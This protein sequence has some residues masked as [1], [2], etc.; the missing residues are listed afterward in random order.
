MKKLVLAAALATIAAPAMAQAP[1]KVSLPDA[2]PALW[3]VKDAD[4]IIYLF[5]TFHMLDGKQDWFND[6]VKTAFDKSDEVVLEALV[7]E[8]QASMVPL[9]QKYAVDP[10]GKTLTSKLSAEMKPRYV[11]ELAA[12]GLPAAAFDKFE[13][14]FATMALGQL[15]TAK[16][17]LKPEHGP[18]AIFTSAAKAKGLPMSQL[19]GVEYQLNLFDTMPE[20]QQIAFLGETL[21]SMGEMEKTLVPMVKAWSSGDTA[22][23][24]K[25]LN[26]GIDDDPALYD[27]L[28]TKRN[29]NWAE[30]I[31]NRLDRPGTVFVAVGAGHLAGKY[32]VQDLLGQRGI[33]SARV[34]K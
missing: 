17:G 5:G 32:S 11:K 27:L 31:D 18:E 22:S 8:N 2:N 16:L 10:T 28:F 9:I 19:E 3:V 25:I 33:K 23:L 1:A 21:D 7:P 24:V 13:P 20:A 29:A 15:A 12:A 6:E 14:W 30:W 4:T 34:P 26:E